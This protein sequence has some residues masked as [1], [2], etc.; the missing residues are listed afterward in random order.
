L[1]FMQSG[2]APEDF[3]RLYAAFDAPINS[4]DCGQKCAP[5]NQRGVPFCCDIDHTVPTAYQA[6]WR[7]LSAQTDLWRLL[8]DARPQTFAQLC[9]QIPSGSLPLVCL[10]HQHCQRDYRSLTCRSF[11]FTPY[12][13]AD[14]DFLGLTYLWEYQ[15]RCWVISNLWA[16]TPRYRRQFIDVYEALFAHV[17]G[18]WE[19]CAHHCE[20]MRRV[21]RKREAAIPVLGRDGQA[22]NLSPTSGALE[23]VEVHDF[24]KFGPYKVAD[25]MPF[26]GERKRQS[27][28]NTDISP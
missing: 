28:S 1:L 15:D 3:K 12:I 22:Y 25:E 24:P 7:Y 4:L 14:N 8:K 10:G 5:Y 18:E 2:L 19:S 16:L 20:E 17:P 23:A 11:P 9:A 27:A 6:E 26:P 13:S 21:F